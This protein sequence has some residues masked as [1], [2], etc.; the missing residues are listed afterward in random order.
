MNKMTKTGGSIAIIGGTLYLL[1]KAMK[2]N[3]DANGKEKNI[4]KMAFDLL[5]IGLMGMGIV[6]CLVSLAADSTG[7]ADVE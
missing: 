1:A 2:S 3:P 6:T 7:L 4:Q 5:G